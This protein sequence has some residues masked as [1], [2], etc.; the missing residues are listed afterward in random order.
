ML[1]RKCDDILDSFDWNGQ[2]VSREALANDDFNSPNL[3]RRAPVALLEHFA[4]KLGE[5]K[6]FKVSVLRKFYVA[7]C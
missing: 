5:S 1:E 3:I 6:G 2:R 7:R 4:T